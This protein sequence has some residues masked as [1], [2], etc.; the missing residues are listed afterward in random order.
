MINI[1]KVLVANR[2]EIA[3]RVFRTCRAMGIGTVAVYSDIDRDA[4]FV[5]E[6]DEAIELPGAAPADTYL[7]ADLII[8]AAK[9]TGADAIHP[10]Y[11]FLAENAAFAAACEGEGLT[12]IGPSPDAITS[13]GSKVEARRL[14][15]SA[16]VAVIP[17]E[18]IE[19]L[20]SQAIEAAAERV[21]FPILVKASAGG[22]G[23]GMRIVRSP[24]E[25][26]DA[27]QSAAREAEAAF[28]DATLY[29]ERYIDEPRHI[30]VQIVGDEH[31]TVVSLFERECSIQRRHQKIIEE[32]PSP[33]VDEAL[34]AQLGATAVKAAQAVEYVGAGT[35]E[36]LLDPN[37]EFFFL[38]MNTR[39]Q[40]EHP[41]TE[42]ITSLD[43]VRAQIRVAEGRPLDDEVQSATVQGHAI[44]ARL[45][46]E[47]PR[48]EF[49]PTTG[50][51]H[52]FEFPQESPVP[53]QPD[54]TVIRIDTGVETGSDISIHYDPMLAKVVAHGPTREE[55][56]GRLAAALASAQ[57]HGLQTNRG[58]LVRILRHPEYLA[59]QTDTHFLDRHDPVEL[60][61]PLA[62]PES[63]RLHALAAAL[64][65]QAAQVATTPVLRTIPSGW[66]NS[67]SQLQNFTFVGESGPIE[68]GYRF[69]RTGL[70]VCVGGQP[71]PAVL[72]SCR[73]VSVEIEIN[74]VLRS[75][76]THRVDSTWYVDSVL[77]HSALTEQSR[78]P[79]KDEHDQPGSLTSPLPGRVVAVEVNADDR[80]AKGDTLIVIEAMKME[81]AVKAPAAGVIASIQVEVDQQV[82]ADEILAVVTTDIA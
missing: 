69:D 40:V 67:P 74:G 32:S 34:R 75:F 76:N 20:D 36:F 9:R 39:L 1:S 13:M 45:Y 17:G 57:I 33:I 15:Q 24:D 6:A 47:D 23:K 8:E 16:G 71:V 60:G 29:I 72:R 63:E 77:G 31:G 12:F 52:R 4:P 25:L 19:G 49:L 43:L 61:A 14:M 82:D 73:E 70:Q 5:A 56:A 10:G 64:A 62:D 55:A 81:H 3:R 46:A 11:G 50:T 26:P 21:G 66:R 30:E 22:G 42:L 2:G 51:L 28:G 27:L 54:H 79:S 41:V 18:E 53:G 58:L 80:V 68:V 59:G 78:F 48:H 35:V 65:G 44:E 37:G 7:R 38:E